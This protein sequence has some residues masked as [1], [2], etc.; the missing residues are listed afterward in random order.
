MK[1]VIIEDER[2]AAEK[3]ESLLKQVDAEIEVV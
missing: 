3:L 2:L 1:I